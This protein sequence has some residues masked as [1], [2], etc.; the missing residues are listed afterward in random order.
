[1][2]EN[3]SND[4]K[5]CLSSEDILEFEEKDPINLTLCSGKQIKL[6]GYI[7]INSIINYQDIIRKNEGSRKAF[8]ML[9]KSLIFEPADENINIVDLES[10]SDE[11]IIKIGK[12]LIQN[13]PNL[14]KHYD[15]KSDPNFHERFKIAL[16]NK[17][18]EWAKNLASPLINMS[19]TIKKA[20]SRV[21]NI[22][23]RYKP[24]NI[25]SV[26]QIELTSITEAMKNFVHPSVTTNKLLDKNIDTQKDIALILKDVLEVQKGLLKSSKD[27]SKKIFWMTLLLVFLTLLLVFPDF[28]QF[29]LNLITSV[30]Y[31]ISPETTPN[32]ILTC[33]R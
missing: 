7:T 32:S 20:S 10:L 13:Y 28:L 21:D 1:M 33:L 23:E 18:K 14:S 25:E 8:L 24:P 6:R 4:K 2:D 11:K 5:K 15:K 22:L 16:E 30:R 3:K 29:I 12:K 26:K 27:S 19:D 31:I 9:L 17:N